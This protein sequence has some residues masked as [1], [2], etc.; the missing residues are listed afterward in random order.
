MAEIKVTGQHQVVDYMARDYDSLLRA[1]QELI[2]SR[3]PEWRP[4]ESEADFGN[5]LLELFAHMGDILSYYQDRVATESFLSTART[6]RSVIDHLKLI[7]YSL[8]TASP[9]SCTLELSFPASCR[10]VIAIE[11]G[12][13]FTTASDSGAPSVRFEYTRDTPL[14]IDCGALAVDPSTQRKHLR[15]NPVTG[16]GGVPVEEGRL[17]KEEH[18]GLSDGGRNQRFPLGRTGLILRAAGTSGKRH[19][20]ILVTTRLGDAVTQWT[21]QES[22][23]FSRNNQKD[24]VIEIDDRDRA[25]I[26][27]GDGA[28]GAVPESGAEITA[29]YRVGGGIMGNVPAGAIRNIADAAPLSINGATVIQSEAATGGAD[30]ESIE[31]AV[32]H[33][34]SVFRSLK[35]A[36]TEEDYKAL[37]LNL[38]G[39]A[40][41][42]A[43]A[44]SWNRVTLHVAPEGGGRVSDVLEESLLAYFE[45]KR[46]VTTLIRIEDVTYVP[47]WISAEIGVQSHYPREEVRDKTLAAAGALLALPRVDFGQTL[48]LSK[49]YEAMEAV[50]GVAF[51]SIDEFR[52][53]GEAPGTVAPS[54]KLILEDHEIPVVPDGNADYAHGMRLRVD[55]SR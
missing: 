8:A 26:L 51:V 16:T 27:F 25:T 47:V 36:V 24:Y 43:V 19:R 6:R 39:V 22:L 9:A 12:H 28:F 2:S 32:M 11:K 20:D 5:V 1:M 34:P 3:L 29:T 23:A 13:A 4:G 49:F 53:E 31:H 52:R 50:E 17:V 41:V 15:K 46:P 30:R 55:G 45:D 18:L 42:K 10:A 37:A 54:G 21:L 44:D 7:G 38:K 48:Y 40:K 14:V 35:R 33:A